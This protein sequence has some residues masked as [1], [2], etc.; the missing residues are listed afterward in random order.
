MRLLNCH[1]D[2]RLINEP[3]N[4]NNFGGEFQRR[5]TDLESLKNIL[6]ELWSTYNGIKHVWHP[7]GWP[8]TDQ[9]LNDYLLLAPG[10]QVLFLNRRNILRRV[11]SSQISEQ[12][13]VW[14]LED[15]EVRN[16]I[17]QFEFR[18]LDVDWLERQLACERKSLA[19]QR[20]LLLATKI[21]FLEL[22][23][24]DLFEA[25]PTF[26]AS[27]QELNRIFKFLGLA[28]LTDETKLLEARRVFDPSQT[29]MNS[30]QT[31][32][33]IPGIKEIEQRFGSDETGWLF[34]RQVRT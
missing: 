5:A 24:E 14:F 12:T 4:Q 21:D 20:E 28:E 11:V 22:S 1:A 9:A 30:E 25:P 16:K 19:R 13:K 26:E 18:P 32:W 2:L 27:L 15:E 10:Q 34:N 17:R 33:K 7:S 23:Y 6:D 8:F 31:Y 3:F 29:R